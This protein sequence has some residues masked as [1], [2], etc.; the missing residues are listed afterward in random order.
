MQ[1]TT[2]NAKKSAELI[3]K[4]KV[5]FVSSVICAT[6]LCC[7]FAFAGNKSDSNIPSA[8]ETVSEMSEVSS[9]TSEN[10]TDTQRVG[11]GLY[12]DGNFV[13]SV[14]AQS[15]AEDAIKALLADR[16]STL[17]VD[18][19]AV[20][21]FANKIE[22]VSGVYPV[23]A[24]SNASSI[25][26]MLS[27]KA[28]NY[29][30]EALPVTLS[31]S[32]VVTYTSSVVI[33]HDVKTIYTDS[34]KDGY[35]KVISKGYDGEGVETCQAKYI[36]GV[37]YSES[38]ISLEVTTPA[39]D[40]VVNVGT[41]SNGITTASLAT[42]Q[43]PYDGYI[44]SYVGPRWGRTH[45][46]IDIVKYGGN[47]YGDPCFAAADGVV[48]RSDWYNGYGK[49]VII[50][51]GNG[52]Q[53]LYGHLSDFTMSVGDVVKAGDEVGKIGSTGRS[54]GPHLH[55]EVRVDGEFVNPLIFVD[56]E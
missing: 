55:F 21:S 29:L 33:E 26:A 3:K 5:P 13:A 54:T 11:C 39:V 40:K 27:D 30:G 46:G 45:N 51:H 14:A 16:V 20:N 28:Y 24:F 56:Y 2:F 48:V 7:V 15:D 36:D 53:T 6:A 52:I 34:L 43:K 42:F 8:S 9:S 47:C 18:A 25:K 49:C 17:N 32:S 4:Y 22:Y 50:D 23:N 12:I 10:N 19:S 41:R 1:K 37:F 31:V 35:E 38:V 44:T